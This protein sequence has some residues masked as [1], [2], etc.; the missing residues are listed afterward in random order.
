MLMQ[1]SL[2]QFNEF[3]LIKIKIKIQWIQFII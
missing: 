3:I 2:I 1:Y